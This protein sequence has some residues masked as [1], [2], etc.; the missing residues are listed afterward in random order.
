L[1]EAPTFIITRK[2]SG[3]NWITGHD[4]LGWTKY[5]VLNTSAAGGTNANAWGN[6]SPTSSV[7]GGNDA[8]FYGNG[9]EQ[10]S[11]IWH[12]VPGL[13]KFG[14]CRGSGTSAAPDYVELGFKPSIVWVKRTDNTGYWTVWDS[15]RNKFNPSQKQLYITTNDDEQDLSADAIDILSD[16]FTIRS[17]SAFTQTG[18]QTYVYCAWAEAP[19]VNLY[20]G[21]SNAR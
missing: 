12:N 16:G 9:V 17:S 18:S 14:S 21:Q 4:A 5:L 2:I 19:T 3:G 7:F 6:S 8:N 1:S 13:Q 20:G 15:N 11:Y 10:I